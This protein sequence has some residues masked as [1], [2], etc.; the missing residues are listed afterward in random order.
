MLS[1]GIRFW[2]L[3]MGIMN[4]LKLFSAVASY[5]ALVMQRY[6]FRYLDVPRDHVSTLENANRETMVNNAFYDL[7]DDE[8]IKPD[9]NIVT[10]FS[11]Q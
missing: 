11:G 3:T 2:A 5:D 4:I 7:R 9:D 8:R 10:H 6:L 1:K